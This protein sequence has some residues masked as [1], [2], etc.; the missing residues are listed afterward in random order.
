MEDKIGKINIEIQKLEHKIEQQKEANRKMWV[1]IDDI[2][3]ELQN[4][5]FIGFLMCWGYI[6]GI[7]IIIRTVYILFTISSD[8]TDIGHNIA[9]YI[10]DLDVNGPITF[11]LTLLLGPLLGAL[12]E[13]IIISILVIL[14]REL[15]NRKKY[16]KINKMQEEYSDGQDE[17]EKLKEQITLLKQ[18]RYALQKDIENG[19]YVKQEEIL[20]RK[21][22]DNNENFKMF[23]LEDL[24]IKDIV[25]KANL[26]IEENFLNEYI[27]NTN[28]Y[29]YINNKDRLMYLTYI[30]EL[31][32]YYFEDFNKFIENINLLKSNR[33]QSLLYNQ[34]R[35][36]YLYNHY[37]GD[38]YDY[39]INNISDI[40]DWYN[41]V[42]TEYAI[43]KA[44]AEGEEIVAKAIQDLNLNSICID[45][46]RFE[47]NGENNEIDLLVISIYG[48][49]TIEVKNYHRKQIRFTRD[50]NWIETY[51][52]PEKNKCIDEIKENHPI[53]QNTRHA[54]YLE[55]LINSNM[56]RIH[57]PIVVKGIV[58]I[59][60]N[61]TEIINEGNYT[62]V[63]ANNIVNEI[64]NNN[65][66]F[67][68]E[69]LPK[70]Q[71]IILRNKIEIAKF[72]INNLIYNK[73]KFSFIK[74]LY[75]KNIFNNM[76]D[77]RV[78][79]IHLLREAE[80]EEKVIYENQS[81]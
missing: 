70:I 23:Y 16:I 33:K 20:K 36:H 50:G 80:N 57:D 67:K 31:I 44:G 71:E 74:V 27:L 73:E 41:E 47:Y 64:R 35:R 12:V 34:N 76:E 81:N 21:L 79:Y 61:E 13:G 54:I 58:A 49:F 62:I 65:I 66:V 28:D 63:R 30:K 24:S 40:E 7:G 25:S 5:S 6:A 19:I 56:G 3:K 75:C 17:I 11:L 29:I 51:F 26:N 15:M 46:F 10:L 48:V 60:N 72:E 55:E 8:I 78:L 37:V 43:T 53:V 59:A 38:F 4:S 22:N 45:N 52:D 2:N 1:K 18:K 14:I 9:N 39:L 32:D 68:K 69:D 77:N 42:N